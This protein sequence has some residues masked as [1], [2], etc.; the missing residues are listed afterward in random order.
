[1]LSDISRNPVRMKSESV[2][3]YR[4]NTHPFETKDALLRIGGPGQ[5]QA[6]QG[7][8]SA[9]GRFV[10]GPG[11]RCV[12]KAAYSSRNPIAVAHPV[13]MMF[14][15]VSVISTEALAVQIPVSSSVI[16]CLTA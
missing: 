9:P 3:E 1:M 10:L 16:T 13:P 7:P 2:S 11:A 4:R 14:P 12:F 15:A 5:L 8:S 6:G